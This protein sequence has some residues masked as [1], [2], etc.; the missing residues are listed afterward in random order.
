MTISKRTLEE[1]QKAFE[2]QYKA[3]QA[4]CRAYDAGEKWEAMR[5]A[6]TVHTLVHDHGK[7]YHSI[8]T[9]LGIRG[10]LRFLSSG[11]VRGD[12]E[13]A[14]S[15]L[16][17]A[18]MTQVGIKC[19]HM[20]GEGPQTS[21]NNVW[22]HEYVQFPTWWEKEKISR[23]TNFGLSRRGLVFA[24]RNKEGG[25]HFGDLD[26]PRYVELK[27]DKRLSPNLPEIESAM[28]R[29]I[30]WEMIMTFERRS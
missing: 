25:G 26:D 28:M 24:L 20:L 11:R 22:T 30:G 27:D 19:H 17:S 18:E 5:I 8:L 21:R 29:Q 14:W 2:A 9:Q 13:L 16:V 15:P 12:S 6:T 3:L 4:S 10:S 23:G 1:V 7:S